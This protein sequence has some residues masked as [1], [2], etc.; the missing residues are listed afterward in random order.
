MTTKTTTTITSPTTTT[1][2]T[3][4]TPTTTTTTTL[5]TTKATTPAATNTILPTTTTAIMNSTAVAATTIINNLNTSTNSLQTTTTSNNTTNTTSTPSN[6][7][8][9]GTTTGQFTECSKIRTVTELAKYQQLYPHFN[10][11][12]SSHISTSN[13]I[14]RDLCDSVPSSKYWK[15]GTK[16]VD[17][18]ETLKPY[19]PVATF[20]FSTYPV[21]G[22]AGVFLGCTSTS[23]RI[24]T[25]EC[26]GKFEIIEFPLHP[27]HLES[28]TH[29]A[30]NFYVVSY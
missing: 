3:T 30:S 20:I 4:T 27:S 8:S 26:G 2:T 21:D 5:T 17:A 18:C 29:T 16:V 7:T 9:P 19:Q 15:P 28:F 22:L 24:A 6:T 14:V 11:D 12:C 10:T 13:L 1:S 25:Q 23:L